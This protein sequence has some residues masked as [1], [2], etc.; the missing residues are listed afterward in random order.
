MMTEDTIA[1]ESR[2]NSAIP[3]TILSGFLGA[4]KT[5]LL[6]RIL[7]GGHGL[8]VAVL[9]NDFGTINI[10]AELVVG[11]EDDMISLANGCV[12]C[13]VRDDLVEAID[14]LLEQP[15]PV[16]YVLLEASGVADPGSIYLTFADAKYRDRMRVDSIICVVDVEQIFNEDDPEALALLKLRQIGFADLLILNKTDIAG[17]DR[18]RQVRAWV[19]SHLNRVRIVEAVL[20]EVPLEILLGVGRFDPA[21]T[22]TDC[23]IRP[24]NNADH[25][26]INDNADQTHGIQFARWSYETDKPFSLDRLR[27]MITTHL[28]ASVYRCKGIIHSDQ[29]PHR[30]VVLQVVGRRCDVVA[31]RPW[32]DQT[33]RTRIVAIGA[34]DRFNTEDLKSLF[35]NCIAGKEQGQVATLPGVTTERI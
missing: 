3:V 13:Q 19:D 23:Q 18:I 5:T 11:V 20:C 8:R 7:T 26:T 6:N 4:G 32:A 17:Q 21:Q 35:D 33:P 10:D 2:E 22:E 25:D 14:Q 31:E 28:P 30:R 12:C 1:S 27:E 34:K 29:D 16:D 9:V 15:K 24:D